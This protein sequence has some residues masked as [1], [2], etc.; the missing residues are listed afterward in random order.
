MRGYLRGNKLNSAAIAP[1]PAPLNV[2][3]RRALQ[4]YFAEA[5]EHVV[6]DLYQ[7]L[8]NEVEPPLLE[9]V[10]IQT[11]HNQVK[12]ARW[13]GLSRGTLRKKL[14]QHGLGK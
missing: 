5:G 3:V 1:M 12:A 11:R 7:A 8:L 10:L 6:P 9:A 14:K 4:C 13:L 2:Q